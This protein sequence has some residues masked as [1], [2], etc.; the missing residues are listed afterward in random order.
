MKYRKMLLAERR[1]PKVYF[2]LIISEACAI[3]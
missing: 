1:V 3:T 2:D